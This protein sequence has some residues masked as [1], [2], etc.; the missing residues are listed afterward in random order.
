MLFSLL[1]VST[2]IFAENASTEMARMGAA[3][4]E[5]TAEEVKSAITAYV[6]RK[7]AAEGNVFRIYDPINGYKPLELKFVK[8][9]DP[10]RKIGKGNY[11]ACSDFS[12]AGEPS[13]LYDLDFWLRA[14]DGKLIVTQ[15][16]IHKEPY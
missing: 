5:F 11:F 10:V 3:K 13:K 16:Q 15:T 1:F 9:H 4:T 7:M 8:I 6:H 2:P 12:V 14:L